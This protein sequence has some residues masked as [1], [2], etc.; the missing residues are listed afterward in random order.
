MLRTK[1]SLA[2]I[3]MTY[4][5]VAQIDYVSEPAPTRFSSHT[6]T[7]NLCFDTDNF[8]AVSLEDMMNLADDPNQV[9]RDLT[10]LEAAPRLS[11][12]GASAYFNY[13]FDPNPKPDNGTINTEIS[14]GGSVV[15]DKEAMLSYQNKDLDTS[16]VYCSIHKEV[17][18]EA[19]FLLTGLLGQHAYWSVGIGGSGSM[20]YDNN[21]LVLSGRYFGPDEH[22]SNQEGISMESYSARPMYFGRVFLQH[23]IGFLAGKHWMLGM[24]FRQGVGMQQISGGRSNT[25]THSSLGMVSVGYRF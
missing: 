5:S 12:T 6:I 23:N 7:M 24:Q 4:A 13:R 25:F 9:E 18:L 2:A 14:V 15:G 21:L 10:G 20:T 19:A 22:P 8:K 11:T 3:L 16:I 1:L 17:G